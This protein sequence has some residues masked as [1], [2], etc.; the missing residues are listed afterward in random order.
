M[1]EKINTECKLF[2]DFLHPRHSSQS[3]ENLGPQFEF[4]P[5]TPDLARLLLSGAHDLPQGG[6]FGPFF[7]RKFINCVLKHCDIWKKGQFKHK[8]LL[9]HVR[10]R[11]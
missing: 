9:R 3:S 6:G 5:K 11:K 10:I 7:N 8:K 1:L 2:N 4:S